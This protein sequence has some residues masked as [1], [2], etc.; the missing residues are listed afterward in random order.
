MCGLRH[1]G[2]GRSWPFFG[3]AMRL[4]GGADPLGLGAQVALQ[5]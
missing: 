2:G 5:A 3:A 1:F 4:A